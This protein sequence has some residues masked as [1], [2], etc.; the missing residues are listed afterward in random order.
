MTARNTA[1]SPS[2]KGAQV[3]WLRL[4]IALLVLIGLSFGFSYL[5]GYLAERLDFP[6]Y[7]YGWL[8]Y[9]IVFAASLASNLTVI[10][11]VPFAASV[12]VDAATTW[13]PALVALV[14]SVGAL[15][16]ELTGYYTGYLGKK[17]GIPQDTGWYRRVEGWMQRY[18]VWALV[19]LSFQPFIPFDLGGIVA[20]ASRMPVHRFLIALWVGRFPKY[21]ILAYVGAG[22]GQFLPF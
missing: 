4:T 13:N 2:S 19:V 5:L 9:L 20:G 7:Q 12:M 3:D 16:G 14:A 8:A 18:G 10:A 21:L 17:V 15:I 1:N 22:F 11:P 6:L